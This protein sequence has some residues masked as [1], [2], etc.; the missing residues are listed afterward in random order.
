MLFLLQ[1]CIWSFISKGIGGIGCIFLAVYQTFRYKPM[2]LTDAKPCIVCLEMTG[3]VIISTFTDMM[4]CL[5]FTV[6]SPWRNK[7]YTKEMWMNAM[8]IYNRFVFHEYDPQFLVIL[9]DQSP[10]MLTFYTGAY[11]I[12]ICEYHSH[13]HLTL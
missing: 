2:R 13:R 3:R 12:N 6:I 5:T 9:P 8:V 10:K 4:I 7:H 1:K 11:M